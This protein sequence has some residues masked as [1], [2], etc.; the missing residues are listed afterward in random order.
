MLVPYAEETTGDH[1]CGFRRNRS[2]SDNIFCTRQILEK[3][4]EYQEVVRQLFIDFEKAYDS[5]RRE[6]YNILI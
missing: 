2:I 3:K 1:Q 4:L 6:I 5:G